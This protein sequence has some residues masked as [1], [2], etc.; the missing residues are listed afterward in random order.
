[1]LNEYD[2][3]FYVS[4]EGVEIENNGVR[5]TDKDYRKL[6][7]QNIQL[8]ITKYRH[9]IKNLIEI[10]G[11]TKERIKSVKQAISL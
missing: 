9:K 6:I 10:K 7:D 8:L 5:E 3:V 4:P 11:S 1:M 2:Y